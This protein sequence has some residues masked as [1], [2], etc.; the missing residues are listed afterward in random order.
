MHP[1]HAR[2]FSR[3]MAVGTLNKNSPNTKPSCF[4]CEAA[5]FERHFML[6]FA[7]CPSWWTIKPCHCLSCGVLRLGLKKNC[8][9][10]PSKGVLAQTRRS[11][12]FKRR[13]KLGPFFHT[14][15]HTRPFFQAWKL[16]HQLTKNSETVYI[17]YPFQFSA[18]ALPSTSLRSPQFYPTHLLLHTCLPSR[19]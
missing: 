17:I 9:P 13:S 18:Q 4:G 19:L 11:I 14:R 1:S 8:G 16:H 3:I 7:M 6:V 12:T 15:L 5:T 10:I 2:F